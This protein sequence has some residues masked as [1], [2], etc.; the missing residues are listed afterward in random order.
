MHLLPLP[1]RQNQ[2]SPV[3]LRQPPEGVLGQ[4]PPVATT[5]GVDAP[6][7]EAANDRIRHLRQCDEAIERQLQ[8]LEQQFTGFPAER[9]RN[10]RDQDG[11]G[12]RSYQ[13]YAC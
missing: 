7:R 9:L 11:R 5:M 12:F 2:E 8:N 13:T 10:W 3:L 6:F 4:D 1:P